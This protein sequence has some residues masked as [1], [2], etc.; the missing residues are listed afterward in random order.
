MIW[1]D[2][3]FLLTK[4]KYSENSLIV[5]IFTPMIFKIF[6]IPILDGFIFTFLIFNLEF[7]IMAIIVSILGPYVAY[8]AIKLSS[9]LPWLSEMLNDSNVYV[10]ITSTSFMFS[11][12]GGLVS[13]SAVVIP[14]YFFL[15]S[16]LKISSVDEREEPN[17]VQ[18]YYLDMWFLLI[19]LLL[20]WQI[21]QSQSVFVQNLIGES[22]IANII[23]LMPSFILLGSGIVLLRIFLF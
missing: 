23:L 19:A 7:L 4:N 6:R 9:F 11:G 15:R 16:K 17:F 3:G 21:S 10:G 5:E 2:S 20:M 14:T 8:F 22:I 18:K 12:L 13:L 1:D